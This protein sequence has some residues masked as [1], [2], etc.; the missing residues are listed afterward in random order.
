MGAWGTGLYS[1]DVSADI[2]G[3][4][5]DLLRRGK[6]NE[7]ATKIVMEK[8]YPAGSE[9][10]IPVFW[11]ALADTQWNYGRL[12][13][14]VKE[15]ALYYLEHQEEDDRWETEA[16]AN[17]RKAVLQKLKE[18]LLSPQPAEKKVSKYN[19]YKCPWKLG[20]V[21]AYQFHQP[22]SEEYGVKGQYIIFR[23]ITEEYTWPGHIVPTV[24]IYQWIGTELPSLEAI[25][26]LPVLEVSDFYPAPNNYLFTL[27]VTSS[28][29]VPT[30][31]LTYLG[32]I[33]DDQIIV[34][35]EKDKRAKYEGRHWKVFEDVFLLRF[36][37]IVLGQ[38]DN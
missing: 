17:K 32:N 16:L 31:Y 34:C 1:D 30:K 27:D 8:D 12:L 20:D 33:Q 7:E 24:H 3:D 35:D 21:F 10:D 25:Q 9:E 26:K 28:R 19:F 29:S 14:E 23:K 38:T 15:K 37:K 11:Y 4:Y 13:P 6:T 2:R 5:V 22:I 18:K 36:S